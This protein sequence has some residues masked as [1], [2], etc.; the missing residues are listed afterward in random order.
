MLWVREDNIL[1]Q[2]SGQMI[3]DTD[4]KIFIK[5]YEV[6]LKTGTLYKVKKGWLPKNE[7]SDS[8][9]KRLEQFH[10]SF[11]GLSLHPWN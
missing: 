10:A 7:M 2:G 5:N 8:L 11:S 3:S 4:C 6:T 1:V 9:D